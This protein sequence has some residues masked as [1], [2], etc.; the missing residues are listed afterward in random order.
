MHPWF[1]Q[2]PYNNTFVFVVITKHCF[3]INLLVANNQRI[4]MSCIKTLFFFDVFW[5]EVCFNL[6]SEDLILVII[7]N[8]KN[9][10]LFQNWRTI[11]FNSSKNKRI[12]N[13]N[14]FQKFKE[15][16][17]FMKETIEEMMVS[18]VVSLIY[19]GQPSSTNCNKNP[20]VG[21]NLYWVG[22]WF[23]GV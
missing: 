17:I 14:Y 21:C 10:K 20:F 3:S 12:A 15:M 8:F 7:V 23:F 1:P 18:K 9:L 11:D 19:F 2:L 5:L 16:T 22:I 6:K 13:S 4:H